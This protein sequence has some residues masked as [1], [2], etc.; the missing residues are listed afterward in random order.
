MPLILHARCECVVRHSGGCSSKI[1][2]RYIVESHGLIEDG[3]AS[4]LVPEV[5]SPLQIAYAFNARNPYQSIHRSSYLN[6][7]SRTS[8][9]DHSFGSIPPGIDYWI[10]Q[11]PFQSDKSSRLEESR[12]HPRLHSHASAVPQRACKVACQIHLPRAI[13]HLYSQA[14]DRMTGVHSLSPTS[15]LTS[16]RTG[17]KIRDICQ[18]TK[19]IPCMPGTSRVVGRL[20]L[21]RWTGIDK[22]APRSISGTLCIGSFQ[23]GIT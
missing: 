20:D 9:L 12:L 17:H 11:F 16:C 6:L 7:L 14:E 13:A 15:K 5:V 18:M 23:T 8:T 21:A 4:I 10:T 19:G 3:T 1:P 2:D 22:S